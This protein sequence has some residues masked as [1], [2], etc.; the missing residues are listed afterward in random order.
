MVV[1]LVLAPSCFFEARAEPTVPPARQYAELARLLETVIEQEMKSKGL[2]AASIVLVDDQQIVWARGFGFVDAKHTRP[3][4]AET[5]Y[6]VGSVSK[7]FTDIGVMQL[8]EQGKLDLDAPVEKYVPTFKPH[9]ASG[10]AITLRQLMT[11]RSGLIREPPVGNYFDDSTPTL[12]DTVRSLNGIP[13]T[14][15]PETRIKYSNAGIAVVGYTLE[16]TQGEPFVR[17]L[18]RAVLDRF[19][20]KKSAFEPT[21]SVRPD[22]AEA[23]MWTYHGRE[24][25]AP[26]FELGMA[27]A[28]SM[29]STVLDLGQFLSVFFNGGTGPSGQVLRPESIAQMLTPQFPGPDGKSDFGIGFRLSELEGKRRAGHGGAVYGFATELA[30]LPEEKLGVCVVCSK[31]VANAVMERL[32]DL[33][34]RG[35]LAVRAGKPLPVYEETT[36]LKPEVARRLAGRY[37]SNGEVLHLEEFQGRLYLWPARGGYRYELRA[38][39]DA[40]VTDGTTGHGL[41]VEPVDEGLRIGQRVWKRAADSL[42]PAAKESY[43]GLLGEYGWDHNVLFIL[44]K[45]GKLYALIE[46]VFLYPLTE[47]SPDVFRFPDHGLYHGEKLVFTRDAG[48]KAT[49]VVAAS[50]LF[51][52]RPLPGE[53]SRTFRITPRRPI[54]E[55]RREALASE[56]PQQRGEF[57]RSDLVDLSQLDPDFKFDI[58]YASD[59]NFLGTKLYQKP[60]ALLQRPAAEALTRVQRTLARQGY[61]LLIHDGYRPWYVTRIFWEATPDAQ[62]VFVADPSQGSRHNRGCAVDLTLYDRTTGQPVEMVGLYD[63]MSDRSYPLYVGGT[64]RQRWHRDL[65]RRAME[66]EDFSVYEAEWWHFDYKDWRKYAIQNTS[67]D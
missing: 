23:V 39:G 38:G 5:V 47:E 55:L 45:E 51:K 22:L 57:A 49:Q 54:E 1:T 66:A 2:P 52:R 42:P 36:P 27:P 62:R 18:Q 6:R 65:L 16:V 41:R 46:W 20:L 17:Y 31:D 29:Y 7:L 9:N 53:T 56:P 61:G 24:F 40:L 3:A 26:T 60:R 25:P 28:G 4:T 67:F 44:E 8:A 14:Y 59:N 35:M 48:G 64:S 32:A 50:V 13:L 43:L 58:R 21:A 33:A 37:V 63:E 15:P 10:K 34:L 11:H 12:A 19:G 30:F